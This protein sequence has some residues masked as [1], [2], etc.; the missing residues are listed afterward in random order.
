MRQFVL[1]YLANQCGEASQIAGYRRETDEA[2]LLITLA[3]GKRIGVCVI[4]RAIRLPEIKE[5]YERNTHAR[6]FT[7]S[8]SWTGG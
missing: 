4:N 2:D 1:D 6:V 3:D 8:T 5:R 7:R